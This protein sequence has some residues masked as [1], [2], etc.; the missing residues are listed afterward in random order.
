MRS[1]FRRRI[2]FEQTSATSG[3]ETPSQVPAGWLAATNDASTEQ[4]PI[5]LAGIGG[6]LLAVDS[7]GFEP[8]L[9]WRNSPG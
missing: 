6:A 2:R 1:R 3:R 9:A 4:Q 7:D 8:P 5:V